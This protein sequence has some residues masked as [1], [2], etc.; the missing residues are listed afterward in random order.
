VDDEAFIRDLLVNTLRPAGYRVIVAR[1][2][3][4]GIETFIEHR[5]DIGAVILDLTMPRMSGREVLEQIH[6]KAPGTKVVVSSGHGDL[7]D[8]NEFEAMG[9][10]AFV[11]KPYKPLELLKTLRDVL[12]GRP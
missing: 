4:E 3:R 10:T 5:R 12:D 7:I 1:D 8:R 11:P 9:A 6:Q 2:G